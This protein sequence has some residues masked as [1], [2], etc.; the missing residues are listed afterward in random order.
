M[1]IDDKKVVS[2]HYTLKNDQGEEL[3]SSLE[4][5]SP[6]TYLHGTGNIIPG[7]EK[8]MAGKAAGDKFEVT[9]EPVEAYGERNEAA[10]QRV[11]AKHFGEGRRL[12]PGQLV[13]LNTKQGPRQVTV[14]KVGRFNIDVDANHPMA[15]QTLTFDVDVTDV[16]EATDEEVSHGHVHGPGGV[17]H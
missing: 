8:A 4:R 17:D 9:V 13:I 5:G 1:N 3:E 2:F 10:I 16:R 11:P 14:L 15:G 7:L 12:E 6:M